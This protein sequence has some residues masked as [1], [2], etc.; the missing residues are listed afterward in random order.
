MKSANVVTDV[1]PGFA[2]DM[3]AQW[4]ALMSVAHGEATVTD[5]I[6]HDRFR[7]VAEL[8]R[9]GARITVTDNRAAIHGV[10]HLEGAPVR[11]TDL[12]ASASLILAGLVARG[13]TEVSDVY[14][15]DRGYEAIEEKL[16]SLGARIRRERE[17]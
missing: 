8:N 14:H 16:N 17:T 9:L 6:Y 13:E 10:D 2:T 7:H 4:T 1:Y 5:T 12:R 3:Q 11:S 15:I